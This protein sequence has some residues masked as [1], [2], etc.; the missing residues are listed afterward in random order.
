[1]TTHLKFN[2]T[3]TCEEV[4]EVFS[5]NVVGKTILITGV[6]PNGL[7]E[8]MAQALSTKKPAKLIFTARSIAKAESVVQTI[9]SGMADPPLIE[10]VQMDLSSIASVQAAA[11]ALQQHQHIDILINNAGVMALP[12]RTLSTDGYEMH[13]G[14]NFLGHWLFT[15]FLMPKLT[16]GGRVVNITSGGYMVCPIRF[17]DLNW[18][19]D[20]ELPA[21]E[22]P[23][24]NMV[25]NLGL[26]SLANAREYNGMLA[27]L[28][29]NAASMLFSVG[30]K[31][32]FGSKGVAAISAA[33]GVVVTELQRHIKGFR[34]PNMEYK[35]A[36]Q[37][38][39]SFL[40]AALDPA[41]QGHNGAYVDDCQM[42]EIVSTHVQDVEVAD[43]TV[44]AGSSDLWDRVRYR[45][46]SSGTETVGPQRRLSL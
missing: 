9:K 25:Q 32:R 11:E 3:T 26:G 12:D 46:D 41:L 21:E 6:S 28:H 30:L 19:G 15:N 17:H 36:S 33:P 24:M 31:E 35:S 1:M 5:E 4:V 23:N 27:Y 38:A 7:G 40:V 20:K 29:S 34:N 37:G 10:I 39:A 44:C 14:T 2:K 8:A 16:S 18:D 43:R 13:F 42:A 22:E 45:A